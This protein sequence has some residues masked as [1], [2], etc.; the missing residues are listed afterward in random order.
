VGSYPN[1]TSN[2][3][4]VGVTQQGD[5]HSTIA[6][7]KCW[8]GGLLTD[9]PNSSGMLHS[10]LHFIFPKLT[11]AWLLSTPTVVWDICVT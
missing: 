2:S 1:R 10:K 8:T 5:Q 9:E 4:I 6:Q 11:Q 3:F 7:Q